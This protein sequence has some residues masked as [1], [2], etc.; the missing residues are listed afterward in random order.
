MRARRVIANI[1]GSRAPSVII[2]M[3]LES[4]HREFLTSFELT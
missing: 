1:G 2:L 3:V 4:L